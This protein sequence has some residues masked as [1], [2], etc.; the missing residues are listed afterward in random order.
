MSSLCQLQMT[1]SRGGGFRGGD[2]AINEQDF[3]TGGATGLEAD[4]LL[5][6]VCQDLDTVLCFSEKKPLCVRAKIY[7]FFK[8]CIAISLTACSPG[9]PL[10]SLRL[11]LLL[12]VILAIIPAVAIEIYGEVELRATRQG[13]FVKKLPAFCVS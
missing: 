4:E 9:R 6:A 3:V 13:E 8:Y 12:L 1:L 11:R 2:D 10:V 7:D 5:T